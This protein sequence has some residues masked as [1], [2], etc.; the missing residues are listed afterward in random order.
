M[1]FGKLFGKKEKKKGEVPSDLAIPQSRNLVLIGSS[2]S[3]KRRTLWQA[4]C[5]EEE[6]ATTAEEEKKHFLT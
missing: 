6:E 5:D 3:S 4:F 2:F 1:L